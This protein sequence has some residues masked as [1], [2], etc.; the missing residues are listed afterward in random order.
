MKLD[1]KGNEGAD[2]RERR[3]AP[4]IELVPALVVDVR[5]E[6]FHY[7]GLL[8]NLSLT[9]AF[10]ETNKIHTVGEDVHLRFRLPGQRHEVDVRG[11]VMNPRRSRGDTEG[12]GVWFPFPPDKL[13]HEMI[14]LQG[15]VDNPERTSDH[16]WNHWS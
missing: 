4:R 2:G 7:S 8:K 11:L 9:G 14:I 1:G 5:S 10:V 16:S 6:R 12:M 15:Q 3:S 13:S